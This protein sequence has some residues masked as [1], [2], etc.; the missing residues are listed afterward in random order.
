MPLSSSVFESVKA[1]IQDLLHGRVA[2]GDRRAAVAEMKRALASAT[3]G[4]EDIQQ[5]VELTRHRL[6]AEREQL[7]VMQRRKAL[8]EGINDAETVAL[9]VKYEAQHGERVAVL[10]R[11]LDAQEA[12]ASLAERELQEM[13]TQLKAASAGAG[14]GLPPSGPD[15]EELGLRDDSGLHSELD[16]L[17]RQRA[18]SEADADAEAKLAALKRRMGR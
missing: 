9:A 7:V 15:D 5:G 3:L 11:K 12:E 10:T 18:R 4:V 6:A 17:A 1:T 16:G 2:P 13:M 8:A 14:G